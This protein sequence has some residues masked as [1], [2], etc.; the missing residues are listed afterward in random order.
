MTSQQAAALNARRA[1]NMVARIQLNVRRGA[2]AGIEA[3]G[4]F[5]A[6]RVR[7][8][9]NIPAPKKRTPDG[10]WR[11]TKPAIPGAPM[12][13]LSGVARRSVYSQLIGLSASGKSHSILGVAI[14]MNARSA[15]GFN[16]PM[17]HER[18]STPRS[19]EHPV[20]Q[21]T[22]DKYADELK[23]IVG[24]EVRTRFR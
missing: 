18:K 19:G 6:N 22:A 24:G 9:L 8:A 17:F 2:S 21:P 15:K 16:Y 13:K 14:G 10:G 5:L 1:V 11:A 12:R 4:M 3:A 20:L 7:D 23:T